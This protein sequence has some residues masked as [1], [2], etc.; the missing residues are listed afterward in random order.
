MYRLSE[1]LSS[2]VVDKT[3]EKVGSYDEFV[4]ELP[5][6]DCRYAVFDFEYEK[7]AGE[8]L[9]NKI[10]FY[11]WYVSRDVLVESNAL[12]RRIR[13]RSS[14]RCCMPRARTPLGRS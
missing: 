13:P 11:V 14:R 9:R 5:E 4:A 1:D 10:L 6:N 2:I 8:G 7:V 3:A 12:G